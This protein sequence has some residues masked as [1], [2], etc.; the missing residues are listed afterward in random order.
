MYFVKYHLKFLSVHMSKNLSSFFCQI[1]SENPCNCFVIKGLICLLLSEIFSNGFVKESNRP[2]A[3]S[4][5]TYNSFQYSIGKSDSLFM[6][7][8]KGENLLLIISYGRVFCYS[9]SYFYSSIADFQEIL[10]FQLTC[11]C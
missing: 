2:T 11:C 1:S 6:S 10:Q 5:V 4:T 8:K 3:F 9:L 7:E